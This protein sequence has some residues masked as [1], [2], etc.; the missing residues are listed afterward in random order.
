MTTTVVISYRLPKISS[1]W[2]CNSTPISIIGLTN[3]SVWHNLM[4]LSHTDDL[5]SPLYDLARLYPHIAGTSY[6]FAHPWWNNGMDTLYTLLILCGENPPVIG[7]YPS[8]TA[9]NVELSGFLCC[10]VAQEQLNRSVKTTC[11]MRVL[12]YY[13]GNKELFETWK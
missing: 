8:Q 1:T 11:E 9:S 2:Q 12:K 10:Q 7:G 3:S 13:V 5:L 6:S 4:M